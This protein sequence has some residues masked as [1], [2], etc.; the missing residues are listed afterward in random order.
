[1]VGA[2]ACLIGCGAGAGHPDAAVDRPIAVDPRAAICGQVEA[3][4]TA[5]A[6]ETVLTIFA[7]NC[8][9]CHSVGNDVDLRPAQAW[10]NLV[11][12]PAPPTEACGGTLVVPGD[13]QASYLYQ[14]LTNPHPCY[15]S[16]MPRTDLFP[17]PL[18]SCVI[19]LIEGWIAEGAPG[20]ADAGAD[21]SV[22][23]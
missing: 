7:Q 8:V 18:P 22:G 12:Q 20:A 16:Q 10:A 14:K 1:M 13:P 17:D 2:A 21:T 6:F 15:G 19:A 23:G 5:V 3:G 4:A 9:I 11:N